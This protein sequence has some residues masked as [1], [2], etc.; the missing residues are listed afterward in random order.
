LTEYCLINNRVHAINYSQNLKYSNHVLRKTIRWIVFVDSFY[1]RSDILSA[2]LFLVTKLQ[3]LCVSQSKV[4]SVIYKNRSFSLLFLVS[5]VSRSV[6][7]PCII[8][9]VHPF[10]REWTMDQLI[11]SAPVKKCTQRVHYIRVSTL[12]NFRIQN[13][14]SIWLIITETVL[15][16]IFHDPA[17]PFKISKYS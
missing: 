7:R 12:H 3:F 17:R 14:N 16:D 10:Q 2:L 6:Y 9:Y 5:R 1:V 8:N 15:F 11:G 4:L 13:S